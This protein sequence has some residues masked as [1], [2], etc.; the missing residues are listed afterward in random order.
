MASS[1]NGTGLTFSSG[2]TLNALPVTSFNGSTGAVS[3]S[4]TAAQVGSGTAGLAA[5]DVGTYCWAKSTSAV[6]YGATV[7]GSVLF[8]IGAMCG[9]SWSGSGAFTYASG[10]ARAGTW[11]AMGTHS[12]SAGGGSV[13][14]VGSCLFLRIS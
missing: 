1:L 6:A 9:G 3:Y 13:S 12:A 11:R 10:A 8:P 5:G 7:A 14:T 4:P 2:Q